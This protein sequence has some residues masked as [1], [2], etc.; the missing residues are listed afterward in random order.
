MGLLRPVEHLEHADDR[1]LVQQ[2]RRHEPAR[3]VARA[4]GDV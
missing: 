2:R 4:L 1:V 3:D